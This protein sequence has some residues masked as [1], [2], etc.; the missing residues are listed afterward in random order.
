MGKEDERQGIASEGSSERKDSGSLGSLDPPPKNPASLEATDLVAWLA[1]GRTQI[2]NGH[3]ILKAVRVCGGPKAVLDAS[4]KDLAS[5]GF[6][7]RAIKRIKGVRWADAEEDRERLARIGVRIV[8]MGDDAYP[9][10][11]AAIARPPPL[12]YCL[13]DIG[14]LEVPQVAMVGARSATAAGK[15]RAFDFAQEISR[16]GLAITSGLARGIDTAAHRGALAAEGASLAVI[17]TG[18][19]GCYPPSNRDLAQE[20]AQKG[21]VV[22]EFPPGTVPLATN[23]PRRNRIISGL[24]LGTLVVEASV[25]SGS[26]IT[27]RLAV[28]EGREV[29][30]IPGSIDNPLSRGCHALIRNGAKLVESVEDVI[31]EILPSIAWPSRLAP[32]GESRGE[33]GSEPGLE[34]EKG[35]S[36]IESSL[37]SSKREAAKSGKTSPPS[38][39]SMMLVL[40]AIGYDPA[41]LDQ[42]VS[43]TGIAAGPLSALLLELELA[44]KVDALP[45]GRFVRAG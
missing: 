17:A 21:L 34:S 42:V 30:A 19:D 10:R 6:S 31:E 36:A 13:G 1:I 29:F 18:S 12:L 24:A 28:E 27:A 2:G 16:A 22:S 7:Q 11:L 33:P 45:G 8:P 26:L 41:T 35:P 40:E 39:P 4:P 25:R 9:L 44:G 3:R 32:M 20:L 43:R 38:D 14:L 5:L 37:E 23:F 15:R